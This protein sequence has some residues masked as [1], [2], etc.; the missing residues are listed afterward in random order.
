MAV[1]TEYSAANIDLSPRVVYNATI[2]GSPAAG[3]ITSVCALTFPSFGRLQLAT[4]VILEAY[5]AFTGGTSGVLATMDIR[6]T[7]TSGAV[8]A[9]S[10]ATTVVATK[11]YAMSVQGVDTAPLAAGVWIIALTIGSGS[12]PSTV[13]AVSLVATAV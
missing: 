7:G 3:S 13:S 1:P 2:V 12:A 9:S 11:L 5:V 10:G 4:G 6:Q 8:I